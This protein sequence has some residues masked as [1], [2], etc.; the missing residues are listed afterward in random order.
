MQI[1]PA[2]TKPENI[3]TLVVILMT[4]GIIVIPGGMEFIT[5]L[6]LAEVVLLMSIF[7]LYLNERSK[8]EKAKK[9]KEDALRMLKNQM[10]AIEAAGEGIGIMDPDGNLIFMNKGLMAV[11]GIDPDYKEDFLNTSWLNLY[12]DNGRFEIEESILPYLEHHTHWRGVSPIMR[13]D[14][15]VIHA[16]MSLTKLPDGGMVGTARDVSEKQKFGQEKRQL[17]AQLHHAQKME[18]IGRLAGGIAHDFNNILAA[19]NGYAEFLK[20]DLPA[21]S[22]EQKFALNILEAGNQARELVDQMLAFSRQK[23]SANEM[24]DIM[25]IAQKTLSMLKASMPKRI[26]LYTKFESEKNIIEGNDTQIG[27]MLMNLCVNAKDAMQGQRGM[28]KMTTRNV[29]V[30]TIKWRKASMRDDLVNP[31]ETPKITI[32]EAGPGKAVLHLGNISRNH[33]YVQLSVEDTGSGMSATIMENIFEPF[34]TT[35]PVDKGTGLGLSTV[36]GIIAAHHGALRLESELGKGTAFHIFFPIV[37]ATQNAEVAENHA[38]LEFTPARILFVED[39]D[40]VR[41]V[42]EQKLL[43]MGYDVDCCE[44]GVEALAVLQDSIGYYDLVLTDHNM[45]K[46]TGLELLE[47]V[48]HDAPDLPFIILSGYSEEKMQTIMAE[49]KGV[50]AILRKPASAEK[51]FQTIQSVLPQKKAA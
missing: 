37:Q 10:E 38:A 26:E 25:Q 40:N 49:H 24:L 47:Q 42:I 29:N 20:E 21:G 7:I 2:L 15:K 44:D 9:E 35:K 3:A 31:S 43:R 27:Q 46:M 12:S 28:L 17:E 30:S 6:L 41:A 11:Y 19:M 16:E 13:Q 33:D 48:H 32:D 34:F 4:A 5:R 39:Q 51:L 45:P 36:L 23:Q 1:L 22:Q 18:A 14:G 8:S 50:K